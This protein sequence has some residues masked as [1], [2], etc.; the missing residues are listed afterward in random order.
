MS[1]QH[2]GKS[3]DR[4]TA[5]LAPEHSQIS[6]ES[7][8]NFAVLGGLALIITIPVLPFYLPQSRLRVLLISRQNFSGDESET[9]ASLGKP[10]AC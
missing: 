5:N 1:D 6:D 2:H 7:R 8:R 9:L 10:H 4:L 3:S